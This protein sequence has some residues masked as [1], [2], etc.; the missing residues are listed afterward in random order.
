MKV[1]VVMWGADDGYSDDIRVFSTK[2]KAYEHIRKEYSQEIDFYIENRYED[3]E[4]YQNKYYRLIDELCE[5]FEQDCAA[6]SVED[7][8]G[9]YYEVQQIEVDSE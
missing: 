7:F 3:L 1:W 8:S 4:Y 2:E 9:C 5:A 6:F